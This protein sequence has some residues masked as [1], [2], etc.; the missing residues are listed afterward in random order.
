LLDGHFDHE[1][2]SMRTKILA[3]VAL[4]A[5]ILAVIISVSPHATVVANEVSGEIYAIDILGL[6]N[7]A[8]DLPVQQY[9][10]H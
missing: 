9:A 4:A 8:K 6:T 10:A 3:I 5:V 1:E 7:D 2:T